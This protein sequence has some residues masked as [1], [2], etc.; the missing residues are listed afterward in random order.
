MKI[1]HSLGVLFIPSLQKNMTGTCS[2]FNYLIEFI[3]ADGFWFM[4][5][6]STCCSFVSVK[7]TAGASRLSVALPSCQRRWRSARRSYSRTSSRNHGHESESDSDSES[8][9]DIEGV[10]C[11]QSTNSLQSKRT[12]RYSISIKFVN[13][14]GSSKIWTESLHYLCK[15][16]DG[17]QLGVHS[18]IKEEKV[19][20][21]RWIRVT[22]TVI[23]I[24]SPIRSL[25]FKHKLMQVYGELINI[26][27]FPHKQVEELKGWKCNPSQASYKGQSEVYH[28]SHGQQNLQIG[29]RSLKSQGSEVSTTQRRG[30]DL[31]SPVA[32]RGW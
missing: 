28:I 27:M 19:G 13:Q 2:C 1:Y 16:Q 12:R 10:P 18:A 21:I 8:L 14:L 9:I 30:Q 4:T 24:H 15:F 11:E 6:W 22:V 25:L 29:C 31:G 26:N 3:F 17:V 23:N 32:G 20:T 7:S 5:N